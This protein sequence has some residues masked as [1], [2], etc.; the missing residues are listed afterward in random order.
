MNGLKIGSFEFDIEKAKSELEKIGAE[1]IMIQL[2]D[3]LRP[4]LDR[5]L[6]QFDQE[7]VVWGGSCYGACDLPEDIGENDVLIHVGHAEIPNLK[8]DYPIIY[9]PGRSIRFQEIPQE[10]FKRLEGKIALYAPVQ[11]LHQLDK[12]TEIL[13]EEGY[14]VVIGEGDDRIE[15]PGQVLGCNYSVRVE[16]AD[17]HLYLG[18]GRFHPLGLSFSLM[19]DVLIYNPSTGQ[20]DKVDEKER[21]DFL[22]KRFASI[23]QAEECSKIGI[24]ISRKKGQRRMKTAEVIRQVGEKEGKEIIPIELDEI[25]KN[26]IDDL[27]LGCAVNTACPRISLDDSGNYDTSLLTPDELMIALGRKDWEDWNMDEID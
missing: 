18:T 16:D 4:K 15:N 11:H 9:L 17:S 27:N 25:N 12:L 1:K 7:I 5:F 13:S 20:I 6:E 8:V 14:E 24:M 23:V 19:R 2:P 22:R 21:D 26:S 3:G 10:L